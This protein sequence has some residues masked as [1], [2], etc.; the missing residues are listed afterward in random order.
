ML[1]TRMTPSLSPIFWLRVNT[2][3]VMV[4]TVKEHQQPRR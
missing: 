3:V 1:L 4:S 2:L